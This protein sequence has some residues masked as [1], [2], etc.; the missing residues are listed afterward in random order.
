[1][2]APAALPT[3]A[4]V[5]NVCLLCYEST[6]APL[7][8]CAKEV[9]GR[10]VRLLRRRAGQYAQVCPFC[11]RLDPGPGGADASLRT[12]V[13]AEL[14]ASRMSEDAFRRIS[15]HL[16]LAP[17]LQPALR[18]VAE[19]LLD[20]ATA[21]SD[22][23][24]GVQ[25]VKGAAAVA[26]KICN[27]WPHA[28]ESFVVALRHFW[29]DL[30]PAGSA[31]AKATF[32]AASF[33]V[34]LIRLEILSVAQVLE[35]LQLHHRH[36]TAAQGQFA[37]ALLRGLQ[38]VLGIARLKQELFGGAVLDAAWYAADKE[39]A[40]VGIFPLDGHPANVRF[41]RKLFED[42][43]LAWLCEH[44]SFQPLAMLSDCE[45]TLCA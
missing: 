12:G 7:L 42:E 24:Q 33:F 18:V 11:R 37:C 39:Y 25:A 31:L 2:T 21:F 27:A 5:E 13:F 10:C 16:L 20:A 29:D 28:H 30:W 40:V 17:R 26:E 36:T 1:M 22:G 41:V 14:A 23:M 8:C 15:V 34:E 4:S 38:N 45:D 44:D 43:G 3:A 6:G 35:A 32:P 19:A 9:C